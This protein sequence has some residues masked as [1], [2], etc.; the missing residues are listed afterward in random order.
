[1]AATVNDRDGDDAE[2]LVGMLALGAVHDL[3]QE[4]PPRPEGDT[5]F[6][7]VVGRPCQR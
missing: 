2:H 5:T 1:L 4:A 6:G 7:R 3:R